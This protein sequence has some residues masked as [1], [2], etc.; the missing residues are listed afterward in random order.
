MV[1]SGIENLQV[2]NQFYA[3]QVDITGRTS[4]P[5]RSTAAEVADGCVRLTVSTK[6]MPRNSAYLGLRR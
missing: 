4:E 5:V 6:V 3:T 1:A 2:S